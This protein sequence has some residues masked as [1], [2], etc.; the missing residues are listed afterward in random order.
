MKKE[1]STGGGE[2]V[3]STFVARILLLVFVAM[4]DAIVILLEHFALLEGMIDRALVVRPR[5]LKHVVEQAATASRGVSRSFAVR[6]GDE[7]LVDVFRLPRSTLDWWGLL[8]PFPPPLLFLG[9]GV[10]LCIT[11]LCDQPAAQQLAR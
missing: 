6:S 9:G 10:D 8:L 3:I 1:F 11:A 7:G 4:R 2:L 5:L